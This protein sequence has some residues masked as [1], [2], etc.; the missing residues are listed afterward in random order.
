MES[1]VEVP[2]PR[3]KHKWLS[4]WQYVPRLRHNGQMPL[5]TTLDGVRIAMLHDGVKLDDVP[6]FVS[7]LDTG[8]RYEP[9]RGL[10]RSIHRRLPTIEE[11]LRD[12]ALRI[13]RIG[14]SYCWWL[15][16]EGTVWWLVAEEDQ[17]FLSIGHPNVSTKEEISQVFQLHRE[18]T[19][20]RIEV[21][22]CPNLRRD[23]R[24]IEIFP[25]RI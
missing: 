16:T 2:R 6:S 18:V 10:I 7:A 20:V 23:P 19:A 5:L 13:K 14:P 17:P 8:A 4:D 1:E 24:W 21:E 12:T 11:R 3:A 9:R 22:A 15:K 25:G